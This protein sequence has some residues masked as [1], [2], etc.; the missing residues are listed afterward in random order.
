MD[1]LDNTI[2]LTDDY[3]KDLKQASLCLEFCTM[4]SENYI[5]LLTSRYRSRVTKNVWDL[6]HGCSEI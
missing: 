3:R 1:V 2:P 4:L 5:I 6:T